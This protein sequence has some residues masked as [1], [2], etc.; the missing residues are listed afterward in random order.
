MKIGVVIKMLY[1]VGKYK[2]H[3]FLYDT[4]SGVCQMVL[5]SS[6]KVN[7]VEW[8]KSDVN[9]IKIRM[10]YDLKE[11][12]GLYI[13]GI[14]KF[15]Y[16][17]KMSD[18]KTYDME[19]QIRLNVIPKELLLK[20]CSEGYDNCIIMLAVIIGNPTWA[21]KNV[22]EGLYR[23]LELSTAHKYTGIIIPL[24]MFKYIVELYNKR[25]LLGILNAL[26]GFVSYRLKFIHE[27]ELHRISKV[28][29]ISRI[30]WR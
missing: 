5:A 10:L 9:L 4:E 28:P 25:D 22:S 12:L 2:K 18:G 20:D 26:D 15:K 11:L 16:P 1:I 19:M 8:R 24:E 13:K 7:G 17:L 29:E 30:D 21:Y 6:S 3:V 14:A 27:G 23:T